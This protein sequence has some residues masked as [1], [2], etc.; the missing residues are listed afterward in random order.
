MAGRRC[1]VINIITYASLLIKDLEHKI[2][3]KMITTD[4][5]EQCLFTSLKGQESAS[6]LL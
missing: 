2:I 4:S 5:E 1:P 6:D 3:K